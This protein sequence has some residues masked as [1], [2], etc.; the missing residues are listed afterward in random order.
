VFNPATNSSIL[1]NPGRDLYAA[2]QSI[3]ENAAIVLYK[4]DTQF[5]TEQTFEVVG[6]TKAAVRSAQ[7]TKLNMNALGKSWPAGT[8]LGLWKWGGGDPNEIWTSTIVAF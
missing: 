3:E 5:T 8:K 4:P 2:P 7:D 1:F 6:A